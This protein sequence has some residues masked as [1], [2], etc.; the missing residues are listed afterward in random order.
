M[1]Y[2]GTCHVVPPICGNVPANFGGGI[3]PSPKHDAKIQFGFFRIRSTSC[4]WQY[5][6]SVPPPDGQALVCYCVIGCW[7]DASGRIDTF[8]FRNCPLSFHSRRRPLLFP[9]SLVPS[10]D[11]GALP[12]AD[13]APHGHPFPT[14]DF[15]FRISHA[16]SAAGSHLIR[17]WILNL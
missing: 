5:R 14:P 9:V 13:E 3:Q 8:F 15:P 1:E 11:D 10:A 6:R 4:H 7:R 12:E 16:T 17:N 2:L